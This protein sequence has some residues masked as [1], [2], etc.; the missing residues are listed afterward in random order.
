MLLTLIAQSTIHT[1]SLPAEPSGMSWV[2]EKGGFGAYRYGLIEAK[3]GAWVLSAKKGMQLVDAE[4]LESDSALLSGAVEL[5]YRLGVPGAWATLFV[6]K[7]KPGDKQF[8]IIGFKTD[9][10]LTIGSGAQNTLQYPSPF[11]GNQQARID[12]KRDVFSLT[13]FN[14]EVGAFVNGTLLEHGQQRELKAA[15]TVQILG[16]ILTVG[17]RFI[18]L[19]NPSNALTIQGNNNFVYFAP[20]PYHPPEM[21][22]QDEEEVQDYFY[23]APRFKRNIEA[24]TFTIDAPPPP[25][26]PDETPVAMKIGPSLV[27]ALAAV[28]SGVVMFTTMMDS[29]GSILRAMPMLVMAVAMVCGA[30]IWPI[31]NKRFQDKKAKRDEARRKAVYATYLDGFRL[32]IEEETKLQHAIL[33][34]NRITVAECAQRALA[35]DAQLMDR[36]PAHDDFLELRLGIGTVGL[37]AEVRYPDER[38]TLERDELAEVVYALSREPREVAGAP[39]A[40]SLARSAVIGI[41][42]DATDTHPFAFGLIAQIATLHSYEDVK[43]GLLLDE[44]DT[45]AWR[46]VMGLPHLFDDTQTSRLLATDLEETGEIGLM[47]ERV[48]E[49]RRSAAGKIEALPHYVIFVPSKHLADKSGLIANLAKRPA[50]GM[51]IV[52]LAGSAKDL[53]KQCGTIIEV[54]HG[55]AS[56]RSKDDVGARVHAF[57]PDSALDAAVYKAVAKALGTVTLDLAG[58]RGALP[59][60][61]GFLEMFE[62]GNLEQLNVKSRWRTRAGSTTLQAQVGVDSAGEPFHLNLHEAFHGP[63]G[64]IA[65]TTGSG[66]S[67]FIITWILSMCVNYSP[68]DVAFVLIDYK[69]GGLSRAFENERARLPHLAGTITNLDGSALGRSLVSIKSELKRRQTLMGAARDVAGGDNIDIYRY[70]ELYH[71]GVVRE[72][73]PHLFIVADEFA[74]LKAQEPAFM[75]ELI[76]AARIGRSLGVHLVLATQKPSGVVNDQIWSNAKFKV[77]LKVADKADSNEMI[78]RPDAAEIT[79]T[80]RFYLLVGYNEHFASGQSAYTGG[81][82]VALEQYTA[83]KDDSVA[84]VSPT[85]RVLASACPVSKAGKA[86]FAE[87]PASELVSVLGHL[88]DVAGEEGIHARKLWLEPLP[89]HITVAE[90]EEKYAAERLV[91]RAGALAIQEGSLAGAGKATTASAQTA[92]M[93]ASDSKA[94][95]FTLNPI[96]GELDDPENQSQRLLTLPLSA[97]GNAVVYGSAGSGKSTLVS[98]VLYE[99]MAIRPPNQFHVYIIDL[100]SESLTAFRSAP[101]VGDVLTANDTERIGN[102]FKMLAKKA[103]ER[104]EAFSGKA[105]S[106]REYCERSGN[107]MPAI[108]VVINNYAA[109]N[110]LTPQLEEPLMVLLRDSA[111]YGIHFV[112]C[113]NAHG[114]IRYRMASSFKQTLVLPMASEGE[115]LSIFGSMRD[116]VPPKGRGRGLVKVDG[117]LREFQVASIEEEGESFFQAVH[118]LSDKARSKWVGQCARPAGAV[119]TIPKILCAAEF[120][121]YLKEGYRVPVGIKAAD[122]SLAEVDLASSSTLLVCATQLPIAAPFFSEWLSLLLGDGRFDVKLVDAD[123]TIDLPAPYADKRT[124]LAEFSAWAKDGC[125]VETSSVELTVVLIPEFVRLLTEPAVGGMPDGELLGIQ[126]RL[127]VFFSRLKRLE[128]VV[129]VIGV[130]SSELSRLH[131]EPWGQRMLS[132]GQ[133]LWVGDGLGSQYTI[134]V[135][136]PAST[137]RQ[138][139]GEGSGFLIEKGKAGLTKMLY[140]DDL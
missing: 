124:H 101:H 34:E 112:V 104:K 62:A 139:V 102:L 111:R 84:L 28:F 119:P 4:G 83:P 65:G 123:N 44:A 16:L 117:S 140:R 7:G 61:L 9:E 22:P 58:T 21:T 107:E 5:V 109:F 97:E 96:I 86:L 100:G 132:K 27:M 32:R 41:A 110:E 52:A 45:G 70:L 25:E 39:V 89:A 14:Q 30:V 71:L 135:T 125:L 35:L 106:L 75:D 88:A 73:C 91:A 55:T 77:C 31:I 98:T 85:G 72:P 17:H 118:S 114:D 137:L 24:R 68:E 92:Q 113:A 20:P 136:T 115:Y 59:S 38:F 121:E 46:W 50:P 1:F 63:H 78:K 33:T 13:N 116:V 6:R 47:L 74:E 94:S 56:F 54:A 138:D 43:L 12:Y 80:G 53:P 131:N 10:V 29:G 51:T 122:F 49:E 18:S 15:D 57:T 64:L 23:P 19:N 130:A 105:T 48:A 42:G 108:L 127:K 93:G 103:L 90:L 126:A 3:D 69:G 82:Y 76:S 134:K 87:K 60:S 67:E 26:R 120:G 37:A 81:P 2:A 66:K 79:Q 8:Q 36:T 133:C 95:P 40:V 128:S 11:I 129:F 99:C